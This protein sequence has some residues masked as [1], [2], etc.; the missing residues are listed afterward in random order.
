MVQRSSE[1]PVASSEGKEKDK[2]KM[3]VGD[4]QWGIGEKQ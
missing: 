2:Q 4:W 3:V 1:Q